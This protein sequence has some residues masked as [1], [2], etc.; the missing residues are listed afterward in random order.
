MFVANW[1]GALMGFVEG[2]CPKLVESLCTR[3]IIRTGLTEAG[4]NGGHVTIGT[5]Y[6][7]GRTH[8]PFVG[9]LF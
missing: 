1:S 9:K 5:V 6:Y 2:F 8:P 3:I 7:G 4:D